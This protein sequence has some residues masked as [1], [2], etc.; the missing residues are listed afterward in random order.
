MA[1]GR[2]ILAALLVLAG[3]Q[4]Q[5]ISDY[6]EQT[7]HAATALQQKIED[8][9]LRMQAASESDLPEARALRP[10]EA[11]QDFYRE[12]EV[13]LSSMRLRAEAIPQNNLTI[14]QIGLLEQSMQSMRQLHIEA[15]DRG[16][17]RVVVIPLRTGINTQLGAIIKLEL[18]KK[19]GEAG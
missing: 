13:D 19:R 3:C 10:F 12:V 17:R 5:F 15:G 1:I 9:L 2:V 8:F 6:D 4:V 14:E 11:N 16:L 18:A 7:D